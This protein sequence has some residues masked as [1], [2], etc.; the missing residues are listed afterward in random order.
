MTGTINHPASD[1][2]NTLR[3]LIKMVVSQSLGHQLCIGNTGVNK[4]HTSTGVV[5]NQNC[6]LA[7]QWLAQ[8][9]GNQPNPTAAAVPSPDLTYYH[10]RLTQPS[11]SVHW[12]GRGPGVVAE[13]IRQ[14]LNYTILRELLVFPGQRTLCWLS[15]WSMM[16][17]WGAPA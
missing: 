11:S 17:L 1:D 7:I 13:A 5:I 4:T 15:P 9:G 8:A 2:L 14:N 3:L 6:T 16:V 12:R 10:I